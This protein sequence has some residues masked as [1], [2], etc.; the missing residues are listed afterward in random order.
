M[1][2]ITSTFIFSVLAIILTGCTVFGPIQNHDRGRSLGK[3]NHNLRFNFISS[4]NT[5]VNGQDQKET[6]RD[7]L[8]GMRYDYGLNENWD[9]GFQ[10]EILSLGARA[11]Y[12]FLNN[13]VG[14]SSSF[15]FGIGA[16]LGGEYYNIGLATSYRSN[17]WEP[18]LNYR[19]TY[20]NIY[21]DEKEHEFL[22]GVI[23]YTKDPDHFY[24]QIF[25]GTKYWFNDIF[26][27]STEV[28]RIMLPNKA[29]FNQRQDA[30]VSL[31]LDWYW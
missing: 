28:S 16:G 15:S 23:K 13:E 9:I 31:G 18:F 27:L 5:K 7:T 30:W 10:Y 22:G 25:L 20:A 21:S 6:T 4:E 12:A 29:G 17:N 19:L 24:G 26:A 11:K 2:K 14:L 1:K 3:G 8:P